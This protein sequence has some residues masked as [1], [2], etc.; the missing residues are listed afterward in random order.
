MP[1]WLLIPIIII[2]LAVGVYLSLIASRPAKDWML[3]PFLPFSY[4]HRGL[5]LKDQTVS[6]NSVA[7]FR[8]A[9]EHG[10][11]AELDVQLSADGK[12]VVFHDDDLKRM[13]GVDKPVNALTY[14]ELKE[15]PLGKGIERI[16][17]F[18]E[19]LETVG[20]KVP[21]IVE[22]KSGKQNAELCGKTLEILKKYNGPY[23]IESFDPRIVRWFKKNAPKIVRG[24]L[25][26]QYRN[27]PSV[28]A[29]LRFLLKNLCGNFLAKPHFIAY[30]HED[31]KD[32]LNFRLC[33]NWFHLLTVAWTVRD[34]D[35]LEMIKRQFDLIIFEHFLP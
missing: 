3:A 19:V 7:A 33:K 9:V 21:L 31:A 13:C 30:R 10:Y 15:L 1:I 2:V 14:A 22:L 23:C 35:D 27:A 20:G 24:Q 17:L 32:C 12:V 34:G 26:D 29:V 18:T 5:Y 8:R 28:P 25:S 4:A 6:E 11:G 16:P